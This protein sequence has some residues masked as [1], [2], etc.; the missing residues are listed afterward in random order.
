MS[1]VDLHRRAE[2][3]FLA[4]CEMPPEAWPEEARRR[5]EGD[6]RLIAEVLSLLDCHAKADD[7]LD[8]A[9]IVDLHK[10]FFGRRAGSDDVEL[11]A[12]MKFGEYLIE[13]VLGSG[14]MG[15]VYVARQDRPRRT[16]ALKVVRRGMFGASLLR[17]FEHEAEVLGRLQHPGIAQIYEAGSASVEPD[18][19]AQPFIAMEL[20]RGRSLTEHCAE[21]GLTP[22]ERMDLLARVCDAVHH[23][24]QRGVIH[25]DLKPA[26]ILVDEHG[27]P[28]ILDF[29]VARAADSDLRVTTMQ[30]SVGQL[31]GTLPYMSPEQ[32]TGDPAE[33]D[34]RS[35]VYALGVLLFQVLT[36][37]LPHDVSSRS[38]PE[39]A[40][41]IREETPSRLSAVSRVF[42]GDV[43]TIVGKALEKDKARRYQS[44]ADLGED[45]R[46]HITGLPIVA[47]EDSA[48]YVLVKQI[49]RH[50]VVV[51]AGGVLLASLMVF[52]SYAWVQ[53][54]RFS[55]LAA[56][57]TAARHDAQDAQRV[58]SAEAE[59][60]NTQAAMLGEQLWTSR[61]ERGR[62]E[63]MTGN[64]ALAE[65][66]L[67]RSYFARARD[68]R[69]RWALW[70]LYER[71]PCRWTRVPDAPGGPIAN[72]ALSPE[73]VVATLSPQGRLTLLGARDGEPI[74]HL[75]AGFAGAADLQFTPDGRTLVASAY[76][77]RA[78]GGASCSVRAWTIESAGEGAYT[79]APAGGFATA[80][81]DGMGAVVYQSAAFSGDAAHVAFVLEDGT[82][83]IR[84]VLDGAPAG[85]LTPE[86]DATPLVVALSRRG[87]LVAIGTESGVARVRRVA[88]GAS[89]GT[90]RMPETTV[91][92]LGFTPDDG[93]LLIGLRNRSVA[94]AD[95]RSGALRRLATPSF[96]TTR[97]L[98]VAA[99]GDA[100]ATAGNSA[101]QV[102]SLP[103]GEPLR[104][105]S[106][107]A[108]K[109]TDIALNAGGTQAT[110]VG[111]DGRVRMWETSPSAG[112]TVFEGHGSWA[113]EVAFHRAS[114]TLAT[115]GGEGTVRL[116]DTSGRLLA[117]HPLS[118]VRVRNVRYSPAGDALWAASGEGVISILDPTDLSVRRSFVACPE[119]AKSWQ[120]E[121]VAIAFDPRG[122]RVFVAGYWGTIRVFDLE[123]LALAGEAKIPSIA[124]FVK[125]LHFS[126]D[127]ATLYS[128]GSALGVCVWDAATLELRRTLPTDSPTHVLAFDPTG[129]TLAAG[130]EH[131]KIILFD[132]ATLERRTVLDAHFSPCYALAFSPS[133][134]VLASGGDD[135][136]LKLWD[137]ANPLPLVTLS[138]GRGE[139]ASVAFAPDGHAVYGMFRERV[140]LGWDIMHFNVHIAGNAEYQLERLR[141]DLPAD[142]EVDR[143]VEWARQIRTQV[144]H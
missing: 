70:E 72:V 42:R 111:L 86:P 18:K 47:K 80:T 97:R 33:V 17:R 114:G 40:R 32:V 76:R 94:L 14:G 58:A 37:K 1:T 27:Q 136:L 41:I 20:V 130:T 90:W 39:A 63:G 34:T 123:T 29:G 10:G 105:I 68:N 9:E 104:L 44:A 108:G 92:S 126:K 67:W 62:L 125:S 141:S 8:G 28:K 124:G 48:L 52:A 66:M 134:R 78:A 121:A 7:F 77:G 102:W 46:R 142:A 3:V 129:A 56:S 116:W 84:R 30:T 75:D 65:D 12:G 144:P 98:R 16:V 117:Q 24:H 113:F 100:F 43:E 35:D 137:P 6:E 2:E 88:D 135:G 109:V 31:I 38:I 99:S 89:L 112:R 128:N 4:V 85:R 53:A 81:F 49:R 5:C 131:G 87:D 107:H 55:R 139:C 50:R 59:R 101:A 25:R 51:A 60:A 95:I 19:P 118:T 143:I 71:F 22:K 103:E 13:G 36:G 91:W 133:G 64:I 132:L 11:R 69:A 138:P 120:R 82:V 23:A 73:G 110:T 54:R 45:L 74:A 26:N 61:L 79:L 119:G 15:T 115:G 106:S 140:M 93:T 127:G 83:E 96:E 122:G 57:E 21:M